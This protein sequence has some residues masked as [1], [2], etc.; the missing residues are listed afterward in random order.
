MNADEPM[1]AE[2]V[3]EPPEVDTLRGMYLD[4]AVRNYVVAGLAALGLVFLILF[5]KNSDLGG[6]LLLVIGGAGMILRWPAAPSF[7]LL[8]LLY[9][10]VFPFGYPPAFADSRELRAGFLRGDDVILAFAVLLYLAA[11]Y[12]VYAL[13]T[14]A[15]P[16]EPR[17]D[18][19]KP[20]PTRRPTSLVRGGEIGRLL[21]LAAG[22]VIVGQ[23]VWLV[24]TAF[25]IDVNA[26]FPLQLG[27]Q[28]PR[29]RS[30][31]GDPF[32]LWQARLLV[33]LG[34]AFFGTLLGRLVFGYW[35][36]RRLSAAQGRILL[37]D[38]GW[39][40]I[41]REQT[42]IETWRASRRSNERTNV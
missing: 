10:L 29:W 3:E 25:E 12:R 13:T 5:F 20:K 22:V 26:R 37:Q 6:L 9:F 19:R 28:V 14:Q 41:R 39:N 7:F 33:L 8:I 15:L 30:H 42:R 24:L 4:Q 11:H 21:Y 34:L 17:F 38:A 35:R 1:D 40:E 16:L 2:I 36:L 27:E 31:P 32:R 18:G 23:L